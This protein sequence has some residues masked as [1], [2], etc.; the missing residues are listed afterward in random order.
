M[1]HKLFAAL[2]ALSVLGSLAPAYPVQAQGT[3]VPYLLSQADDV[4]TFYSF[5]VKA[6]GIEAQS[7]G[8]YDEGYA[9]FKN[10]VP[11]EENDFFYHTSIGI[12]DYSGRSLVSRKRHIG[13]TSSDY[14]MYRYYGGVISD[15][16]GLWSESA[17]KPS[18]YTKAGK[19]ITDEYDI[20]SVM[21]DGV[22]V[23]ARIA[24]DAERGMGIETP[25]DIVLINDKNEVLYTLPEEFCRLIWSGGAD[26]NYYEVPVS[27]GW[28]S[29]GRIAFSS[30][31]RF[32]IDLSMPQ[33]GDGVS[34]YIGF[35]YPDYQRSERPA[36]YMDINGN[37]IISQS[38]DDAYP[39]YDGIAMVRVDGQYGYIDGDGNYVIEPQYD[40]AG[41]FSTGS[42]RPCAYAYACKDG[43]YGYID[44]EG[45]TVIPF[46]YDSAFGSDGEFFAVGQADEDG[47]MHYG[48]VDKENREVLPLLFD[49]ITN[50]YDGLVYAVKDGQAYSIR[51]REE[52]AFFLPRGDVDD[53][54]AVNANDASKV[55]VAAARI[56]AKRDSGLD[57]DQFHAGDVD[58]DGFVNAKDASMIL[59]YAAYVGAKGTKTIEAYFG[60]TEE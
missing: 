56:G 45:S 22:A 51:I 44:R 28:Y 50:P 53:N 46:M 21:H 38:F 32:T 41:G 24:P 60:I 42:A 3:D 48:I 31:I 7:V 57:A 33:A 1:K 5:R 19:L 8:M 40:A 6:L 35:S 17:V 58:G 13:N 30:D 9:Y 12:I 27:F 37:V 16:D 2:A 29:E 11:D 26:N 20:G 43:Q 47:A 14:T 55:L 15:T 4:N 34:T 52:G 10:S 25:C 18:Y 49:D 23:A 39:F 36:G 59:R 54:I